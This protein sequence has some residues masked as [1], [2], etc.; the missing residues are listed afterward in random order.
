VR[1]WQHWLHKTQ[2]EDQN[3]TNKQTKTN[4]KKKQTQNKNKEHRK[5]EQILLLSL[6]L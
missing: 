4:T 2:G 5:D 6:L 3:K 1:H